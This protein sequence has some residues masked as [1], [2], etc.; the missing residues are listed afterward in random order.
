MTDVI[1]TAKNGQIPL[2]GIGP[3]Q[4]LF[5]RRRKELSTFYR[6]IEFHSPLEATWAKYFD[7]VH[8]KWEYEP[9]LD[10]LTWRPD[11]AIGPEYLL[12]EVRPYHSLKE[13]K[14]AG[15]EKLQQIVNAH[16]EPFQVALLGNSP[17]NPDANFFFTLGPDMENPDPQFEAI[18]F[19][20]E[21]TVRQAWEPARNTF[22][23]FGG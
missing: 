1:P 12:A 18:S 13:W 2:T 5:R 11:F 9:E 20:D 22:R 16:R 19:G 17:L 8:I 4:D 23:W 7:Q 6:G 15:K 21:D 14:G 3:G 10:L